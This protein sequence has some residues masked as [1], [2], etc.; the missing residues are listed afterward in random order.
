MKVD[1]REEN[2]YLVNYIKV[3]FVLVVW[4]VLEFFIFLGIR[5]FCVSYYRN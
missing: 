5:L 4:I 1:F 2:I 3:I